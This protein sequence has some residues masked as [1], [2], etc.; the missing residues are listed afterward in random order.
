VSLRLIINPLAEDDL[1][2][3]IAWLDS[4]RGGLGAELLDEIAAVLKRI[5]GTP[6]LHAIQYRDLRVAL[7]RRF[8]YA[9]V[10]RIDDEQI[11]V[12]AIYHTS[13]HPRTWQSRGRASD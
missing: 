7:V 6:T 3:A 2:Q 11:T 10:Y 4:Q 9:V 1:R 13:R 12:V 8:R 5:L